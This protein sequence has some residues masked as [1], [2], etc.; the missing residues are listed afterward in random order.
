MEAPARYL[1]PLLALLLFSSPSP[2][3]AAPTKNA[4][5]PHAVAHPTRTPPRIDG[6]LDDAAWKN[7]PSYG[8][9][10][11]RKP[12][13]RST[14]PVATRF[15]VIFD[16]DALYIAVRAE[17]DQPAA[18][19]SR[20]RTRDDFALFG[21][22]AISLK[23]DPTHDRRTT[24]GFV[25]N[26]GGAK[27]DYRGIDESDFRIEFDAV[28]QGAAK[29]TPSGW[30]AEFRIPFAALGIHPAKRPATIGFNIT[31]DHARRNASYDWALLP[32]PFSPIAASLYGS[33]SGLDQP[34]VG[35]AATEVPDS[36]VRHLA[37][38]PYAIGGF[39]RTASGDARKQH[40]DESVFSGG[41]DALGQIG[42]YATHLTVN[43]DFAQVELDNQTVN[44]SPFGLF[45]PE[46]RDF[47]LRDLEVL[48][49]GKPGQGQLLYSRRIGLHEGSEVP[50]M[51]GVKTVGRP[52]DKLR[53]GL[54]QVTTRPTEKLPWTSHS[55]ARSVFEFG[56]GANA[57][58]M[59]THRG[60]FENADDNNFAFGIDGTWR[61]EAT[62]LL[63][64]TFAV[65]SVTGA[66]A[67]EPQAA[68][69]GPGTGAFANRV[70]P[71]GH[72]EFAWRDE[73]IRP[74][75][76]YTY[77]HPEL[78]SDLGFFQRVG[79][80]AMRGAIDIEPRIGAHGI[81]KFVMGQSVDGVL[82]TEGDRLLD[83]KWGAKLELTWDA[84]FVVG[85]F[86]ARGKTTVLDDFTVGRG[87]PVAAGEYAASDA[88]AYFGT[89]NT[90]SL[91]ANGFVY[92]GRFYGG[93][94]TGFQIHPEWAP[95]ALF[96]MRAG[97]DYRHI[98]FDDAR[99][100]FDSLTLNSR[101]TFGFTTMLSLNS[102]AGYNLITDL[103]R[104]QNRLRWIYLP[105]SDLFIV[106]Q[107]DL[108][109]DVGD[110]KSTS[111]MVKTSYHWP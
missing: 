101:F 98:V 64:R 59:L 38:V 60:S 9:F 67:G 39:R 80:H 1:T 8:G 7:A 99:L 106:Q 76:S 82:S 75:A 42:S 81:R 45:L 74:G 16:G 96:R 100:G 19:R 12:R 36:A 52:H 71:G 49:F 54:L 5:R 6:S 50:I 55:A 41:F 103:V 32:P 46:K 70:A 89:P 14:P 53:V 107:L 85:V 93:S 48:S 35:S 92:R 69:G 4:A 37:L 104:V 102:Y 10:V 33:L 44:F 65:G 20:T 29:R 83:A 21:D 47:F 97:A 24:I 91:S 95:S 13:L 2:V 30:Q 109:D 34:L 62:P 31:R 56:G 51:A 73:L 111:F 72:V 66:D 79:I 57:G 40:S 17:D 87:T 22:D 26:P 88:G 110:M 15:S 78:R 58:I 105:G 3:S 25:I 43:T 18:I 77:L 63:V 61:S 84:G 108:D 68:A 86:A 90:H 28:W 27:L 23:I 11:E 94:M